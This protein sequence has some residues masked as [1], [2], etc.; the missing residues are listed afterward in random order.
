VRGG[1]W[2]LGPKNPKKLLQREKNRLQ[3]LELTYTISSESVDPS[4][5][6]VVLEIALM[7]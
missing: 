4:G 6:I 7:V 1:R 5:K 2:R 3:T